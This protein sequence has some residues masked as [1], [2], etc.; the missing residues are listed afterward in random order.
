M[1]S[2]GDIKV[3]EK[4]QKYVCDVYSKISEDFSRTRYKVWPNVERFIES[5]PKNTKFLEIGCGN[6]KNMLLRPDHFTGCDICPEFVELCKK[7]GLN[8]VVSDATKLPFSDEEFDSA[9]SI[10]VIHHLST[11]E[12]RQ[13]AIRE[14]LRVTKS[15]GK[16]LIEVWCLEDNNR[17]TDGA[18]TMVPWTVR[19][20]GDVEDETHNRYYHFFEKDEIEGLITDIGGCTIDSIEWEKFNWIVQITKN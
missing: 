14:M 16:L 7:R 13:D 17:A 15:G 6:G 1:A 2:V 9:I 18:D 5:Q 8:A 3:P 10:A 12:R 19:G 4:E 20:K 11:K